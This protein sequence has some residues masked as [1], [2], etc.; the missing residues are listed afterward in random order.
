MSFDLPGES[1]DRYMGRYARVLAPPFLAFA[2]IDRG[3]VLDVG[4]GPGALTAVLAERF[5]AAQ[6]A[7]IDPSGPFVEACRSRVPGVDVRHGAG[8][9]LPFA[10]GAFAG[11]LSQLVIGFVRDAPRFVAEQRRVVRPGSPIAACMW[12]VAQLEMIVP[13]WEAARRLDPDARDDNGMPFRRPGELSALWAG[14]GLANV[15]E[16]ELTVEVTYQD[17]DDCWAPFELGV[18]PV[19]DYL[20]AQTPE[21]REAIREACRAAFGDPRGPFTLRGVAGAVRGTA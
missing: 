7:A 1:Y 13:F 21:R 4:C 2:D 12:R 18:G 17:F 10:D 6:V 11:A 19:G 14:A 16:T 15:E 8:E 9:A 20:R 5:G 3:P